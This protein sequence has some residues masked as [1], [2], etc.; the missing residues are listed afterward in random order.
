MLID[1]AMKKMC[2]EHNQCLLNICENPDCERRYWC[3]I[4]CVKFKS[5]FTQNLEFMTTIDDYIEEKILSL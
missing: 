5:L 1:L 3:G 2:P 4:C